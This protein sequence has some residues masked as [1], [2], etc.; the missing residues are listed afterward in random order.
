MDKIVK[1]LGD[2]VLLK[3]QNVKDNKTASGIIIPET[4]KLDDVT[5]AEVV[6]VSTGYM[7][8]N[9]N[10]ITLSVKEGDRVLLAPHNTGHKVK[11]GD[12]EYHLVRE[13]EILMIL[14]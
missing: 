1:P 13:S 4:V 5:E 14:I 2:R 12:T 10:L 9:G 8:P 3:I 7:T 6:A 11:L